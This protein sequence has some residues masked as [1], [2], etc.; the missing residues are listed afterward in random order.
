MITFMWFR[1]QSDE[2][3]GMITLYMVQSLE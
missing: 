2:F 3:R 1:V